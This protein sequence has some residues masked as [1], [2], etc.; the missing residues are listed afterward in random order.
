MMSYFNVFLMSALIA[1][2]FF[3]SDMARWQKIGY[4]IGAVTCLV[5]AFLVGSGLLGLLA[6]VILFVS[7]VQLIVEHFPFRA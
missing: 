6:F 7:C 5:N 2:L 1:P 4:A 3:F